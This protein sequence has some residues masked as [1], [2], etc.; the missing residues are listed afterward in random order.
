MYVYV[1]SNLITNVCFSVPLSHTSAGAD[2]VILGGDLNM[3]PQD[4]GNR[5]LRAYTGLRDSFIETDTF[6][7][8]ID[9]KATQYT[10]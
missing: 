10:Y 4:L 1:Y 3:H 6:D 7:V 2:A 8:C 9:K 5:L